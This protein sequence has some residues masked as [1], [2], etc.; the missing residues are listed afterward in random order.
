MAVETSACSVSIERLRS[1]RRRLGPDTVEGSVRTRG[2]DLAFL[3][4]PQLEIG[5]ASREYEI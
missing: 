3:G 4:L 1:L 2:Q 5:V